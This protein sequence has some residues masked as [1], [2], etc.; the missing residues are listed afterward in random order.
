MDHAYETLVSGNWAR[1]FLMGK[2]KAQILN[3]RDHVSSLILYVI[4]VWL[5]YSEGCGCER[6]DFVM[7]VAILL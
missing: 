3:F 6:C 2:P 1:T 5:Y 4:G 7:G